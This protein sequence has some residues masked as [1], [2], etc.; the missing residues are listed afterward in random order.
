MK[1]CV[2]PAYFYKENDGQYSVIFPDFGCATCGSSIEEAYFMAEDCL[3][4]LIITY[5][6]ENEILPIPSDITKIKADEYEN[7]FVS[8]VSVDVIEY[9]K[10]INNRAV[11][12]NLTIPSWL[13][14]IAEKENINFSKILQDALRDKL[15]V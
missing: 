8:L 4:G 10:K 6:D 3:G 15:Q 1:N 5:Q 2:Y 14:D 7:G 9:R 13:N 11:K 12:K